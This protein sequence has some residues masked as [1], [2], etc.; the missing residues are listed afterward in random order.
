MKTRQKT[1][2][3]LLAEL[4]RLEQNDYET[5]GFDHDAYY[6]NLEK[7]SKVFRQLKEM[8]WKPRGAK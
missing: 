7:K 6:E 2:P 1:I 4:S 8:G 3:E 5:F